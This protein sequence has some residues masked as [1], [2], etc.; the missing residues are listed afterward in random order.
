MYIGQQPPEDWAEKETLRVRSIDVDRSDALLLTCGGEAMLVD[1]STTYF[2]SRVYTAMDVEG[3]TALKYLFSTH[4]DD[5]HIGG[6][7]PLI[8]QA[9]MSWAPYCPPTA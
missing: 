8:A 6:F 4:S 5:D 1:A 2:I 9:T 7:S 3:V